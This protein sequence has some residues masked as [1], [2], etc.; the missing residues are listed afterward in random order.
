[1]IKDERDAHLISSG[2]NGNGKHW[3]LFAEM[4]KFISEEH[5]G[6]VVHL[7][8]SVVAAV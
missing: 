7:P 5:I 4:E 8:E 3:E 1:V 2:V 6:R